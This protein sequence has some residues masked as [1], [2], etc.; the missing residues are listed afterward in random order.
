ISYKSLVIEWC[1]KQKV[2]FNY[3]V[4]EE[5][6]TDE[7]KH[8]AVKQTIGGRILA[9][10]RATS[11]KKA[12]EKASKR[13]FFAL[14]GKMEN[15]PG[16]IYP[17]SIVFALFYRGIALGSVTINWIK[18]IFT[19]RVIGMLTTHRISDELYDDSYSLIA[20]HS[21]LEDY[22]MTYAINSECGLHLKRMDKDL[23]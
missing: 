6:G 13:A 20:I 21:D 3:N 17:N 15:P 12:E 19:I 7:P 14:Q 4:Y 8:F 10:A 22:A 16:Y 23:P 18:S 5:T 11:K 2:P 9:K 1:Q